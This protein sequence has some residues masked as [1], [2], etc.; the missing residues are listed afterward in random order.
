MT[1]IDLQ[2]A[3]HHVMSHTGLKKLFSNT[4]LLLNI[5]IS[6]SIKQDLFNRLLRKMYNVRCNEFLR[7]VKCL[8]EN[9]EHKTQDRQVMLRNAL[10][11][12]WNYELK[13]MYSHN[14]SLKMELQD[15]LIHCS[16]EWCLFTSVDWKKLN[17][18]SV[19]LLFC[20]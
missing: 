13:F 15:F 1:N 20:G 19:W 4:L 7:S 17:S 6:P 8:E 10:K 12:S 14:I 18:T 3:E 9:I 11:V 5:H 16:Q 2:V